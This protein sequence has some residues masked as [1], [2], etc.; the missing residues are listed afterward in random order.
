M[1]DLTEAQSSQAVKIVGAG[2][3]S[4]VETNFAAVD[5]NGRLNTT[6][7]ADGTVGASLPS[8]AISV[9][10]SDGTNLQAAQARTSNPAPNDLGIIV[11]TLPYRPKTFTVRAAG[12]AIGQNKSMLSILNAGGSA[13]KVRLLE[14]RII[15][16]QTVAVTGV[17]GEFQLNRITA[18][19][20]GT[21]LTPAPHDTSDSLNA[22][23]TAR[24]GAT[25]T[26]AA[27]PI[28]LRRQYWSTDEWG[29]GS[30][31]QEGYDHGMQAAGEPFFRVAPE[32]KPIVLNAGEGIH[33]K[34][35]ANST[36]GKFDIE[37]VFTEEAN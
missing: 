32:S 8:T 11:R 24:T 13:V 20:V 15:N 18:H 36:A 10:V 33:V 28:T 3:S 9:G 35:I 2:P 6:D 4:A 23:V 17:V 21:Q 22:S 19:S 1:A 30:L 5:A 37:F 27:G 29:F 7:A 12:I 25:A 14:A 16:V 26:E 31:D 34:Q